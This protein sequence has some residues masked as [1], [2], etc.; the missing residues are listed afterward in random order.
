M[1]FIIQPITF[2]RS[3]KNKANKKKC[4]CR[5]TSKIYSYDKVCR[6]VI[7]TIGIGVGSRISIRLY[8][9]KKSDFKTIR[10]KKSKKIWKRNSFRSENYKTW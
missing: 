8:K 6:F 9:K 3:I 7:L 10:F 1:Y 2:S 4:W 5:V